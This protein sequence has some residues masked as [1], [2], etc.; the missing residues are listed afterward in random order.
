MGFSLK[1]ENHQ[2]FDPLNTPTPLETNSGFSMTDVSNQPE[3]LENMIPS[4][5]T[6]KLNTPIGYQGSKPLF[7][8]NLNGL[9]L[10]NAMIPLT[11]GSLSSL[12]FNTFPVWFEPGFYTSSV[13]SISYSPVSHP[14]HSAMLS[15]RIMRG[16]VSIGM[17]IT[18]NTTQSG[19]IVATRRTAMLRNWKH[20]AETYNGNEYL[21]VRPHLEDFTAETFSFTDVSLIRTLLIKSASTNPLPMDLHHFAFL[22]ARNTPTSGVESLKG[23]GFRQQYLEDIISF[24]VLTDLPTAD[25]NSL[26]FYFLFDYSTVTFEFPLLLTLSLPTSDLMVVDVTGTYYSGVPILRSKEKTL[27]KESLVKSF[28][29]LQIK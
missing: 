8:V 13:G 25:V 21:N 28:Q 4:G 3:M 18:S 7:S 27:E 26:S 9:I 24:G 29:K 10:I 19:N 16:N 22:L 1:M 14:V 12:Y 17:R 11:T 15:H 2:T 23:E 5:I 20:G 6:L